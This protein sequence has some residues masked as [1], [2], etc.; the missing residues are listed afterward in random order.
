MVTIKSKHEIELMRESC[1]IVAMAQ[2]AIKKAIQSANKNLIKVPLTDN[3]TIAHE[4]LLARITQ[5]E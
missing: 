1:K 3:R 2:D 4:V 5:V